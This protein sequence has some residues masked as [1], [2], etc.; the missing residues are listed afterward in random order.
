MKITLRKAHALQKELLNEVRKLNFDTEIEINEFEYP[1]RKIA[2]SNDVFTDQ[3]EKRKDLLDT[4]YVIRK[5]VAKA[6]HEKDVDFILADVARLDNDIGFYNRVTSLSE[7][8]VNGDVLKGKLEKIAKR[9]DDG[10]S[11]IYGRSPD[12]VT[13]HIFNQEELKNFE[14]QLAEVKKEKQKLQDRLLEIN[15]QTE[16]ELADEQEAVLRAAN[17]V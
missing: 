16:V 15:F 5:A 14:L 6:N 3:M 9:E 4:L 13:T 1:E 7:P 10:S 17:L 11:R 8:R 12:I 2:D